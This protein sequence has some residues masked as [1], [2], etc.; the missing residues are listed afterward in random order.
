MTL[1]SAPTAPR[2]EHRTDPGPALGLTTVRPR[3]SWTVASAPDG[4]EQSAYELEIV[5]G[6]EDRER[7]VVETADQA[8]VPWP[9]APL[10][11][12]E[13]VRVRVRVKSTDWSPWSEPADAEAGLLGS[14]DW[15]ARF[16]TPV[17]IGGIR[18]AAPELRG[19]IDVPH[20]VVRARLFATAHGLLS[21]RLNGTPID[22]TLLAPGWT[23]YPHRL[24]YRAYDVTSLVQEG[25]NVLTVTL[26]NGWWRGRLG[27][28]GERAHYGDRLA[29]LGQLEVT[30]ADG[31]VHVLATD[32]TWR[33]RES[34]ILMDDLYDGQTTDLR[35]PAAASFE[36]AVETIDADL[37][38][39][40]GEDGPPMR[41]TERIEARRVWRSPS[42]KL[43]ADFG[44]NLVGW[45]CL[46]VRDA[47]PGQEVVVRHAEVLDEGELG[48]GPL[49][50][51]KA[52]DTF[53]LAGRGEE[54]L[55]PCF[56]FHGFRYAEIT[57]VDDI[58]PNDIEAVVVGSDLRRA[59]WFDS[60]HTLLNQ[61]HS[62]VVWGMRGNFLD[63]PTDCPQRD[64]RLGW[65]GDIQ[66]FSPTATYLFDTSGFLSS[67]LADVAAEQ[68]PSG[69]VPHV[70]PDIL[71][72]EL[73]STPTAAWGDAATV[74][75]W[76]IWE[77]TGD[78]G[79]LERQFASM[80][81]WVDHV[82]SISGP[83]LIWRG[84]I[85]YGDW[86]DPTAP[87]DDPFNAKADPDIIA[88]AHFAR[89]AGIVAQAAAVIGDGAN[90]E[91]YR[92]LAE[93]VRAAFNSEFVTPSGRI[94]SEAQTAYAMVLEWG[95]LTDVRQRAVAGARLA[96]LVRA[97]AFRI[98]TGFVGTPLICD[99]LTNA[100]YPDLAMRLLLQTAPPSWLYPVTVGATTVWER[101]DS[102]LPDG[103]INSNGM[104][105]FNHYALGSVVDWAHRRIAG[106]AAGEPGYRT[107][108]V[109]PIVPPQLTHCCT[110]HTTPYGDAS[111]SW[112]RADGVLTLEVEV[113]VGTRALVTLPGSPS[114]TTVFHGRHIWEVAE[115]PV[116][117]K[118]LRTIRDLVDDPRAWEGLTE[119]SVD[120]GL[121]ASEVRLAQLLAPFFDRP[122]EELGEAVWTK[123]WPADSVKAELENLIATMVTA[124]A[125]TDAVASASDPIGVALV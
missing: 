78:R 94:V 5:R 112:R 43:L 20:Q 101:W 35:R 113:P 68:D 100:G 92:E 84:G 52:T 8:L 103:T 116:E 123:I 80:R 106:L 66:V 114:S 1:L 97:S 120:N 88:T 65:T 7:W 13:T 2:F 107:L 24:R 85:Q 3:L 86:L 79:I 21:A 28:L 36:H 27:F 119:F 73:T 32:S 29:F 81:A 93:R 45:V 37:S 77:R 83:D 96:D 4:F 46:K 87:A 38:I 71:R 121:A 98:S 117:R 51:A 118:P 104:T 70:V 42:G 56:T 25:T 60:S 15:R 41:I 11:A 50:T 18:Q 44:Q 23:S 59:G 34:G 33:A 48:I 49:R 89:S 61:L 122:V 95:L 30:T 90:E 58:T 76:V 109:A 75:P 124:T 91:R 6:D 17:G 16:I 9:S 53:Y 110:R 74:V 108:V 67:W 40:V 125:S 62:N 26:G 22:D 10:E 105:S 57:G 54:Q 55:E 12:R 39:L 63:V 14:N 31:A 69:R 102:L 99:A 82:A 64:E 115:P 47:S 72:S 111:V 19:T